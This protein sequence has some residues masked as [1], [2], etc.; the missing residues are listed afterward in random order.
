VYGE[1][2][3][4]LFLG[5]LIPIAKDKIVIAKDGDSLNLGG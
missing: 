4:K 5:D 3:F 2:F 1:L